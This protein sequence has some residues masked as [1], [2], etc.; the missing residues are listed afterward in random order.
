MFIWVTKSLRRPVEI[1]IHQAFPAKLA[2][3]PPQTRPQNIQKKGST[4]VRSLLRAFGGAAFPRSPQLLK[5]KAIERGQL[6]RSTIRFTRAERLISPL[7]QQFLR[8]L[9][10][11]Q[12]IKPQERPER[13][14]GP[15]QD[16]PMEA[17]WA[18]ARSSCYQGTY[19]HPTFLYQTCMD[20][21]FLQPAEPLAPSGAWAKSRE[22]PATVLLGRQ[23]RPILSQKIQ[24][25]RRVAAK[26]FQTLS[27]CVVKVEW[28]LNG[29]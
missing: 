12:A 8:S 21:T 6:W 25:R 1:S 18:C 4:L 9:G 3:R 7:V 27:S 29:M 14:L 19:A 24:T 28:K 22:E 2:G 15:A 5:G 20:E 16:W 17:S 10:H 13:E 26:T 11:G 23:V